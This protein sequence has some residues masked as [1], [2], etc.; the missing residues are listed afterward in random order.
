MLK[1]LFFPHLRIEKFPPLRSIFDDE[2]ERERDILNLWV[3]GWT[4]F[5]HVVRRIA[6]FGKFPGL[7]RWEMRCTF[8]RIPLKP[9]HSRI[10]TSPS[11]ILSLVGLYSF[12]GNLES[13]WERHSCGVERRKDRQNAENM[14]MTAMSYCLPLKTVDTERSVSQTK[15]PCAWWHASFCVAL[16][17]SHGMSFSFM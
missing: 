17:L 6:H 4:G 7:L 12:Q 16:R 1:L 15:M 13:G 3:R 14:T 9:K 11:T 10:D 5:E 2:R 8:F